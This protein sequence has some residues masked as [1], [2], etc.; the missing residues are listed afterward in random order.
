MSHEH[1]I[2][3]CRGFVIV[4]A[5][6][7]NH[8]AGSRRT[9]AILNIDSDFVLPAL[10]SLLRKRKTNVNTVLLPTSF[11]NTIAYDQ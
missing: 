9:T 2:H 11:A 4:I 8:R 5:E 1:V 10:C 6:L 3:T 7:I